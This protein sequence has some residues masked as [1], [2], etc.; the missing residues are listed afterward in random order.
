[1]LKEYVT[2]FG[3]EICLVEVD[4]K[5]KPEILELKA[6]APALV[7]ATYTNT[8]KF[9]VVERM[10]PKSKRAR[11]DILQNAIRIQAYIKKKMLAGKS[12]SLKELKAKYAKLEFTDACLCNHLSQV[13]RQL[14]LEGRPVVKLGAGKYC[15]SA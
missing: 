11:K 5:L 2:T 1:V 9:K 12:V 14:L 13:R 3:A 6:L 10:L 8:T 4:A 7:D 15:I